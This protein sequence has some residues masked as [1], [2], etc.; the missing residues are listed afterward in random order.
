MRPRKNEKMKRY[1]T[2]LACFI[3]TVYLPVWL[4]SSFHVHAH[5]SIDHDVACEHHSSEVDEDGCLLCQFQ[6]LVYDETPQVVFVVNRVEI[7]V[8]DEV[9]VE[10]TV[11]AFKYTLSSRAPPVLL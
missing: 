8:E 6:Q 5:D 9:A 1:R 7:E 10:A 3:L 2:I 11:Q 4:L